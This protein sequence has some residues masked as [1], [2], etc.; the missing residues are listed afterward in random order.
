MIVLNTLTREQKID[1]MNNIPVGFFVN[2]ITSNDPFYELKSEI[3]L[4]YYMGHSGYKTIS[5]MYKRFL[6]LVEENDD[7][8]EDAN[9]IIGRYMRDR[10]IKKWVLEYNLLADNAYNPLDEYSEIENKD[11]S[12]GETREYDSSEQRSGTDTDTTTY[13]ITNESEDT[14]QKKEVTTREGDVNNDTYGFNSQ[15]SV[16]KDKQSSEIV[17]T[18]EGNPNENIATGTSSKTGTETVTKGLNSKTEHLGNDTIDVD[19]N[20]ETT[21]N[22]RR[23]A[24]SELV[25]KELD[26]R[27]R[28]IFF[29]IVYRDIDSIVTIPIYE[30]GCYCGEEND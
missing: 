15:L 13:N 10:F 3:C 16:P 22:G 8:T 27:K 26:F 28:Q 9:T 29:D 11:G 19:E 17:Q 30:R 2:M 6:K 5:P 23:I 1:L 14:V 21:R 20:I 7:I 12:R 25:E 4:G 18:V 24:G